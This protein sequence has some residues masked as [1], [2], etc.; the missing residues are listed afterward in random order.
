[1]ED[2][3]T[4]PPA[5]APLGLAATILACT[6]GLALMFAPVFRA[7]GEKVRMGADDFLPFYA[8][9]RL[10]GTAGLYRPDAVKQ[11]ELAT[12]GITGEAWSYIRPPFLAAMVWPLSRLPYRPAHWLWLAARIGAAIGF[13]L[14]WPHSPRRETAVACCW[15]L[16]LAAALA[17]GQDVPLLLLWVAAAER[18][19]PRRPFAAGL[20]LSLCLAKFHLLALLPVFL[21]VHRRRAIGGFLAGAAFLGMFSFVVAGWNWPSAY[22]AV[23]R[24]PQISP[25]IQSMP[26]LHGLALPPAWEAA[27]SLVVFAAALWAVAAAEAG[28]ALAVTLLA[29]ILLS[30]HAYLADLTILLPALLALW[31]WLRRAGPPA[32]QEAP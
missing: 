27:L 15:F 4:G 28:L 3:Q 30:Y 13:V 25:S 11:E 8:G 5:R 31:G 14:L 19:Y 6:V 9:A 12:A 21:W 23:L 18:C 1:M 20:A 10:L 2:S 29:G 7:G 32:R 26:N 24:L 22:L 17:N 16:P